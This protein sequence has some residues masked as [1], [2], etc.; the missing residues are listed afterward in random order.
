M[1]KNISMPAPRLAA[2]TSGV[3]S[4]SRAHTFASR[5]MA[6]GSKSTCCETVT[7]AGYGKPAERRIFSKGAGFCGEAQVIVP[8]SVRPPSRKGAG[9]SASPPCSSRWPAKRMSMPPFSTKAA[10]PLARGTGKPAYVA[11]NDDG[12][13]SGDEIGRGVVEIGRM[14]ARHLGEGC[15]SPFEIVGGRQQRLRLLAAFA[16]DNAHAPALRFAV[17]EINGAGRVLARRFPAGQPDCARSSGRSSA[18]SPLEP[19]AGIE[20]RRRQ[21]FAARSHGGNLAACAPW[22]CLQHLARGWSRPLAPVRASANA[23]APGG[24][25]KRR[26]HPSFGQA[27]RVPLPSVAAPASSTPSESHATRTLPRFETSSFS[28]CWAA[29]A[30][31]PENGCGASD[32]KRSRNSSRCQGRKRRRWPC[33]GREV[34]SLPALFGERGKLA[35]RTIAVW[36]SGWRPPSHCPPPPRA[37]ASS[38][39]SRPI[40]V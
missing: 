39:P 7:S 12:R 16:C 14:R 15:Q 2:V 35:R 1:W 33:R 19:R 6:E 17:E 3:P 11:Q 26:W 8:P 22:L 37:A 27:R 18:A 32:A 13:R 28:I 31:P 4:M 21:N 20:R 30:R 24:R 34:K 9:R 23:P 10:K 29:A 38:P 36:P 25:H 5:G 40:A